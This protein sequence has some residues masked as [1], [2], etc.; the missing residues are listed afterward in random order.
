MDYRC[1]PVSLIGESNFLCGSFQLFK[2]YFVHDK[3]PYSAFFFGLVMSVNLCNGTWPVFVCVCSCVGCLVCVW[4]SVYLC[5][6][7]TG[8]FASLFGSH[9]G[10][11]AYSAMHTETCRSGPGI[12]V[13]PGKRCR[14]TLRTCL[15]AE[16]GIVLGVPRGHS[17]E[18]PTPTWNELL[19][20]YLGI[21]FVDSWHAGCA[22]ET[23]W[24][25]GTIVRLSLALLQI[26]GLCGIP[27]KTQLSSAKQKA[28]LPKKSWCEMK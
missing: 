28:F 3:T 12:K 25:F 19:E 16:L 18:S 9:F 5:V 17:P 26:K 1:M 11:L 14:I 24:S 7:I 6:W 21:T 13:R 23:T 10:S 4:V 2:I 22:E 8:G 20:D 27:E 15:S